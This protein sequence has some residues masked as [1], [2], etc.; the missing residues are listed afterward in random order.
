MK[1]V[2]VLLIVMSNKKN[3]VIKED[4]VQAVLIADNFDDEF[5]P[6]SNDVPLVRQPDSIKQPIFELYHFSR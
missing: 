4:V 3:I 1:V 2:D 6:I 5:V